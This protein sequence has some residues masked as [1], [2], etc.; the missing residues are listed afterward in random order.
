MIILPV[1][2]DFTQGWN[3]VVAGN[4]I[5]SITDN[6][7]TSKGTEDDEAKRNYW[8]PIK[9]G[10]IIEVECFAKSNN[11]NEGRVAVDLCDYDGSF[12]LANYI[13]FDSQEWQLYKLKVVVPYNTTYIYARAVFGKWASTHWDWDVSYHSPIIKVSEGY[14]TPVLIAYGLIRLIN[15]AVDIHPTFRSFGIESVE[16]NGTDTVMIYLKNN[17]WHSNRPIVHVTGTSEC[18]NSRIPVAGDVANNDPNSIKIKWSDGTQFVDV[19]SGN[20]YAFLSVF[21]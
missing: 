19:S 11:G 17:L 10:Q 4:G 8:L 1:S 18:T 9:P 6:I 21:M 7:F 5:V 14:G 20:Y 13:S 3:E 16:F 2:Q 12:S 15:G